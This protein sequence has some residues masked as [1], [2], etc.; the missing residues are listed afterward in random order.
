MLSL[1]NDQYI[2]FFWRENENGGNMFIL[3]EKT[4]CIGLDPGLIEKIS[5]SLLEAT[6]N[7]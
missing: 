3:C 4:N 5:F 6:T 7:L 1:G 2:N